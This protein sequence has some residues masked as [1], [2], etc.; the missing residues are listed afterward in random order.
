MHFQ[1]ISTLVA[2]P[3]NKHA[4]LQAQEGVLLQQEQVDHKDLKVLSIVRE[5]YDPFQSR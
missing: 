1:E 5:G 4:A 2:S 3:K